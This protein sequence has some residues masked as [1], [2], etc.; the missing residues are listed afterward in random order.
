[1]NKTEF[2]KPKL[3]GKRFEDHTVPLELFRDFSALQ[4]MLI[5]VAKWE[6]RRSNPDR[7]RIPRNFIDGL[8]LHLEAIEE[9]SSILKI[10]LVFASL[11]PSTHLTYFEQARQHIVGAIAAAES[12][13]PPALPPNLLD[14]FDRFGRG[15]RSGESI[16]FVHPGG[17][18]TLTP[19][20]RQQLMRFAQVR[21]WTEEVALRGRIPEGDH[22]RNSFELEL[23]DG[24]ILK[25]VLGD[26]YRDVILH[27]FARYNSGQDEYVLIQGVAKK[28]RGGAFKSFESI[29]HVTPLDPLDVSLR[30]EELAKLEDGWYDGKGLAPAKKPLV[31]LGQLFETSF[32][33]DLPL[34]FLY[35]TTEGGVQA[36]WTLAEWAVTLEVDLKTLQGEYQAL[37]MKNNVC[38]EATLSLGD[39]SGWE[40]LNAALKI[41]ANS[42]VE[43]LA[44]ES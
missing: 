24:A 7:A 4:E 36:E 22:R 41:L 31:R 1:M 38:N 12:G 14:Y 35:P 5:E 39:Q 44:S 33:A 37:N 3:D 13:T 29:E 30:L 40:N 6:F 32:D 23:A 25:G 42:P 34:P 18:A 21:E 19:D 16:S 8:D 27:A 28:D 26:P 20:I 15:L 43:A 10:S 9:G 11:F 17:E 2:L